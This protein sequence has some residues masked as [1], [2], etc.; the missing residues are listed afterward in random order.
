MSQLDSRV[1]GPDWLLDLF[2]QT[3]TMGAPSR[4]DLVRELAAAGSLKDIL[5]DPTD[6]A[7]A[8][9]PTTLEDFE[10]L[11]VLGRGG[12]GKVM[13]VRHRG[14]EEI[15]A[16]KILK[17]SELQRRRQVE[18][19]QTERNILANIKSTFIVQLYYAFQNESKVSPILC[20]RQ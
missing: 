6:S 20:I 5:V 17:K 11:T 2:G 4:Q 3:R 16:M 19:T 18:R 12:F 7:D 13:Q 15:Y 1:N 8:A 9:T 14:S 10:L